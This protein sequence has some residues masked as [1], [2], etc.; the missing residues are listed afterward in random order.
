MIQLHQDAYIHINITICVNYL[1]QIYFFEIKIF[2]K[3]SI[4]I[5]IT[6]NYNLKAVKRAVTNRGVAQLVARLLWEQDVGSS[7]L[8]TPTT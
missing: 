5:S 1:Q 7:S 2:F 6:I 4:D 8:F 3:I